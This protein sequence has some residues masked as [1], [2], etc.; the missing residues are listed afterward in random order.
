MFLVLSLGKCS[1]FHL[2][3]FLKAGSH[4]PCLWVYGAGPSFP[5][6]RTG[7]LPPSRMP[8]NDELEQSDCFYRSLPSLVKLIFTLY[9]VA[10]SKSDMLFCDRSESHALCFCPVHGCRRLVFLVGHAFSPKALKTILDGG[11][12]LHGGRCQGEA[13][14]QTQLLPTDDAPHSPSSQLPCTLLM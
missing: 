12:L 9:Q 5:G 14:S 1:Y 8:R 3:D 4:P 13:L 2:P 6:L 11:G 10:K 7:S